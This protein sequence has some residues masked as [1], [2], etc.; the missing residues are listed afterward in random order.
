MIYMPKGQLRK[1]T[2]VHGDNAI[3]NYLASI[4][5][6][7]RGSISGVGLDH[8]NKAALWV[9]GDVAYSKSKLA[10]GK[11]TGVNLPLNYKSLLIHALYL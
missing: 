3:I 9:R 2:S 4:N 8:S 10:G 7:G 1:I 11:K 5:A 6:R